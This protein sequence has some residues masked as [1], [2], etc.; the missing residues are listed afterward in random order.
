MQDLKF[1]LRQLKKFPGFTATVVLTVALGIGANTAIF[2]LV[3]AVLLSSLPVADPATLYRIGDRDDCCVNGGFMNDDGDFDIFSYDLYRQFRDN[4]PEFEQLAAFESGHDLSN[5]RRSGGVAK[6]QRTEYVSG[7]YF[8]TFGVSAFAGRTLL[9]ADDLPGATPVAVLRYDIWQSEYAGDRSIVGSTFYM[10]GQPLT[11]VGIAPPKFFGDRIDSDPPAFWIPLSAEPIF[12]RDNSILHLADANWL[13]AIGRIKPGV[14]PVALQSKL[15]AILRQFMASRP[16]YTENGASTQIP[17]Q[18]VVLAAAGGGVQNLQQETGSGLRL[19]ML[20]SG[21][22]LLVACANVANLMLARATTRRQEISVRVALG[23]AR[24][25]LIRQMLTESVVLACAGGLVGLAFAFAGTR[26]ILALAFPNTKHLAI[27]AHPSMVVL[28]FAFAL[29]LITGVVFG[30]VPALI[31]SRS[32]PAEALRGANRS[33]R[34]TASLPQKALIVCQAA[35]S[36][37]LLVAAGLLS[38]TLRNLEHQ[39]FGIATANRYVLH[40]D[41]AGAGYTSDKIGQ[42]NDQLERDFS[43]LPGVQS[44]GLA[45]YSP[46]E[47]D[48]W[49][50]SVFIEGRPDPG[51]TADTGSSWD[52]VSPRFFETVGQQIVRGRG[53]TDQ[54]T[55]TSRM[56]AVVNQAF[57][58]K[59][60]PNQDPIGQHFGTFGQKYANSYEIVGVVADAKYNNPRSPVRPFFFRPITQQNAALTDPNAITGER[61]SLFINS[62]TVRFQGNPQDLESMARRTLASI[63]PDLTMIDFRSLDYQVAGNFSQEH[64]I[65]RL[66]TL[67][68]FLA[69]IL[70]SVGLYGLTAYSVARR[71]SEIGVRMAMGANRQHILALIMRS[72]FLQ[73]ALGLA[74]G[75]PAAILGARVMAAQLYGVRSYDPAVLFLAV[76]VLGACAAVAGF[77]PAHRASGIEPMNALRTE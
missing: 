53:I 65:A 41:P 30:I 17:K 70:A 44:A 28:G 43:A 23:A 1:A 57:V 77:V 39:N 19:L 61:R 71:T 54:D 55:A 58:K 12:N 42:L 52:R 9:P 49:G 75:I 27:D 64:L 66:T 35:L 24:A 36:L 68:G 10:Q 2:T 20:I 38:Q 8:T 48:N 26:T 14:S 45:L 7:N 69:L 4:T 51:P 56:V 62:V 72:A 22:V 73:T 11:V 25:R 15:S 59:F 6:P 31:T 18:H 21:L 16:A 33:T 29:S 3:H 46:L 5:M 34:D 63:N 40:L 76:A 47:G 74:I 13:Y 37:V 50:D 60:F 32:D 67:F